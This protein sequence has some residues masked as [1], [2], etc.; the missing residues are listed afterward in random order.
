MVPII[1]PAKNMQAIS[2]VKAAAR[3]TA[4]QMISSSL[5][6]LLEKE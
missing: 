6:G 4:M 3:N 1:T 5:I 2:I